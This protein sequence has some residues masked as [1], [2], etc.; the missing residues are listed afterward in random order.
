MKKNISINICGT[1]YAIDEDAYQ[2]LD[3]YLDSMKRYFSQE[4]EEEISDDIEHRVAELLWEQKQNGKDAVTIEMVKEIIE[5]IGNP[6]DIAGDSNSQEENGENYDKSEKS[7][8]NSSDFQQKFNDFAFEAGK[9]ADKTYQNVKSHVRNR[10]LYRDEKNKVLGGVCSGLA[11][12]IG[13]DPVIW[14]IAVVL[15]ALMFNSMSSHWWMPNFLHAFIPIFYIILW[16]VVPVASTPEDKIRMKGG[17][18]NPETLKDQIVSDIEEQEPQSPRPV[19]NNG[20]CIRIIFGIMMAILLLPLFIAFGAIIFALFVIAMISLGLMPVLLTE[21]PG[22]EWLPEM[23]NSGSPMVWLGLV[24]LLIVIGLPIYAIFRALRGS[25]STMG[26]GSIM[27]LIIIWIISIAL[28]VFSFVYS[29]LNLEKYWDSHSRYHDCHLELKVNS[30]EEEADRTDS[31]CDDFAV[32]VDQ[33]MEK[34][35]DKL[36]KQAEKIEQNMDKHF[37]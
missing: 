31:I 9:A 7:E 23:V 13:G 11:E 33:H 27:T 24:A 17:E 30:V 10:R 12:Y 35:N 3:H 18:V 26:A 29:G 6:A 1:I 8:E 14:R 4:G 34:L 15:L 21:I 2:L 32:R 28:A 22:V 36:D 25:S 5:K 16:I 20:G 19:N 37:D